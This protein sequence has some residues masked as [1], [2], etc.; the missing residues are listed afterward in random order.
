MTVGPDVYDNLGSKKSK[1]VKR[2][3]WSLA[4]REERWASTTSET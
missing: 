1:T 4:R 3:Q 2:Y